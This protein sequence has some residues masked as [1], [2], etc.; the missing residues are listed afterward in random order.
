[1][2]EGLHRLFISSF[3][4][5]PVVFVC[6]LVHTIA[7]RSG[8]LKVKTFVAEAFKKGKSLEIWIGKMEKGICYYLPLVG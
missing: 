2:E 5:L 6:I 4:L 7:G 8:G 1:M 3:S